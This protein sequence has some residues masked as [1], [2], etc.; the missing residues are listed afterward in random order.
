[1]RVSVRFYTVYKITF[2]EHGEIQGG[3][4]ANERRAVLEDWV[5]KWLCLIQSN[6]CA[7][8]WVNN[9]ECVQAFVL[10][11]PRLHIH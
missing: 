5:E 3:K 6:L 4:V 9:L 8:L 11:C 10:K 2:R 1:M 7:T